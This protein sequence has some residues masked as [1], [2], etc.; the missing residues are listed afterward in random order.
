MYVRVHKEGNQW[1]RDDNGALLGKEVNGLMSPYLKIRGENISIKK[2][3]LDNGFFI[4][5]CTINPKNCKY[6]CMMRHCFNH[7]D[8]ICPSYHKKNPTFG[9]YANIPYFIYLTT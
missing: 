7:I 4:P 9:Y 1:F 3:Y 2:G 5:V 8:N 6:R